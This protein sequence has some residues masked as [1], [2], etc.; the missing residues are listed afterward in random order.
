MAVKDETSSY[1]QEPCI[2]KSIDMK[3]ASEILAIE[4]L[5]HEERPR[6]EL[7]DL[8]NEIY[9]PAYTARTKDL[10]EWIDVEAFLM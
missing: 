8:L 3:S 10:M 5:I 4:P 1:I 7:I 6:F 9:E 2:K